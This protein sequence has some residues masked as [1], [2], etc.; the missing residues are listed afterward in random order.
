LA[1]SY[2]LLYF[3]SAETTTDYINGDS[4]QVIFGPCGCE[5]G[6]IRCCSPGQCSIATKKVAINSLSFDPWLLPRTHLKTTTRNK[7]RP[8]PLGTL[9]DRY[10]GCYYA[11][12]MLYGR[13]DCESGRTTCCTP[14]QCVETTTN[15]DKQK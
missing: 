10:G 6:R 2:F 9:S 5:S 4:C 8:C 15:F 1:K 3:C 7:T 12:E 14:G 13:C 11:C